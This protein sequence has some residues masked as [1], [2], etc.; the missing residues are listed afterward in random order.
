MLW[1][2]LNN[3]NAFWLVT[4]CH[5]AKV[6]LWLLKEMT[7]RSLDFIKIPHVVVV[8]TFYS[9]DAMRDKFQPAKGSVS[10]SLVSE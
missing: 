9:H 10:V 4:I 6:V 8:I 1:L 2:F 5:D 3:R 7:T